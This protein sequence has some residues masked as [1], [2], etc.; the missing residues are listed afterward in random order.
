MLLVDL[1]YG[2]C[3]Y[4]RAVYTEKSNVCWPLSDSRKGVAAAPTFQR[5][6]LELFHEDELTLAHRFSFVPETAG[7]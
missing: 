7:V 4:V 1:R 6:E 2:A 3:D 5:S